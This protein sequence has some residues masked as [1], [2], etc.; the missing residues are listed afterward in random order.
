MNPHSSLML[1]IIFYT[2][3]TFAL[4]LGVGLMKELLSFPLKNNPFFA[5]VVAIAGNF[6]TDG[7]IDESGDS[8]GYACQM[9]GDFKCEEDFPKCS[10]LN[11]SFKFCLLEA[12][13]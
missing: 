4:E 5:K 9:L 10:G 13:F 6:N 11:M 2:T 7:T 12:K 1:L 8:S 3:H